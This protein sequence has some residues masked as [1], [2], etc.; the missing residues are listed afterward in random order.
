[1]TDS[2]YYNPLTT[3]NDSE[4]KT[5]RKMHLAFNAA[6]GKSNVAQNNMISS[7]MATNE[8]RRLC[9]SECSKGWSTDTN[10]W[11]SKIK[12]DATPTT[13]TPA[14]GLEEV[15]DSCKAGCDSERN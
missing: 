14:Q 7:Y 9:H 13:D 1:M 2:N 4:Q 5:L 15:I 8:S 3:V 6:I 11:I 10:S 12:T